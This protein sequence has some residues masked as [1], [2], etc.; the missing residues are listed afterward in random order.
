MDHYGECTAHMK[1]Y[2]QCMKFTGN[3]NAPNCRS[4]A[5]KYLQCRMD[6]NLM[7]KSDWESLGLVDLPGDEKD[8]KEGNKPLSS[9]VR[10]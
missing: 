4:L 1:D 2:L 3:Q 10:K 7:D 5:K 9:D 8:Y 6:N